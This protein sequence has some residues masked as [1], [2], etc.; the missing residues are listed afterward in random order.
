MK[1]YHFTS[2]SAAVRI[3]DE[4]L[5]DDRDG[6]IWLSPDP[7]TAMGENSRGM[8]LEVQI[9]LLKHQVRQFARGVREEVWDENHGKF[10]PSE[11]SYEWFHIPA[12][13]IRQ[14]G[15]VRQL[16]ED[17]RRELML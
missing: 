4:G 16:S 7:Q 2:H 9:D 1:L 15:K 13:I 8:L 11:F 10:V 5:H 17:E 14:F 3:L 6:G 12:E